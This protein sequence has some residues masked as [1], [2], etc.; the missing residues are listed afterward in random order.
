[1]YDT[2]LILGFRKCS[3]KDRLGK[4]D[5]CLGGTDGDRCSGSNFYE[6]WQKIGLNE[7]SPGAIIQEK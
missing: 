5:P 3:G 6:T 4:A 1:M 2:S 7:K